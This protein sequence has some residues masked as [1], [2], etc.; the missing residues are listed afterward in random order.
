MRNEPSRRHRW[1]RP[2]KKRGRLIRVLT[3]GF[4]FKCYFNPNRHHFSIHRT[5]R[6]RRHRAHA[7]TRPPAHH[8]STLQQ[9]RGSARA[10][11]AT[12][13]L[14][15][16]KSRH[17][18][19]PADAE[20]ETREKTS[21]GPR[22]TQTARCRSG[23]IP[24]ATA[25]QPANAATL[26]GC[27]TCAQPPKT[28]PNRDLRRGTSGVRNSVLQVAGYMVPHNGQRNGPRR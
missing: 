10:R 1:T 12:M 7:G 26:L 20:A 27:A 14:H 21:R 28:A 13:C 8:P 24:G 15:I 3:A 19:R 2:R 25:A 11:A 23:R 16:T 17:G 6:A 22:T 5:A 4:C 18:T 9:C